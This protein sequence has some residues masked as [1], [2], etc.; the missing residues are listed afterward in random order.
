LDRERADQ[1]GRRANDGFSRRLEGP[2][3]GGAGA[4]QIIGLALAGTEQK[5]GEQQQAEARASVPEPT[6]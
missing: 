4:K 1:V 6:P 5:P 2:R 3:E